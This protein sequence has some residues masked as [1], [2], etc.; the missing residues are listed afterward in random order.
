M[1]KVVVLQS[2]YIP[3]K[4]YFDLISASDAFILYDDVQFTKNDWRNR[5]KIVCN[6]RPRWISIP[7][8]SRIHRLIKDVDLPAGNWRESHFSTILQSYRRARYFDEISELLRPSFQASDAVKTLSSL[9][10]CLIEAICSYLGIST[11]IYWSWD[12]K[13]SSTGQTER[14]VELCGLVGA[15]VYI[16]GPSAKAYLNQPVFEEAG[17]DVIWF[18]YE[19]YPVYNQMSEIFVHDVSIIDLLFNCGSSSIS[20]MKM[21]GSREKMQ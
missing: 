5:N 10:R 19:G 20:Y 1:K 6:G 11:P 2:N 14:L 21:G 9:N 7:V 13:T 3:W 12:F 15:N 18:D 16:S 4:G 17:I 8:G